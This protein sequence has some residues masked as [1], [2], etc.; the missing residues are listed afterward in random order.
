M[1]T[2]SRS[3]LTV[4][5]LITS[6]N[7]ERFLAEALESAC[8][9]TY[10]AVRVVAVDDGSTDGSREILA[11]YEDRVDVLLKERGGQASAI[12]AGFER[13]DGDVLL[14]LDA[15]DRLQP[16]AAARVVAAFAAD[17]ELSKVQF[18]MD[19]IDAGGERTG[20]RRPLSSFEVPRG[21]MRAAEL[22]FPLDI[23]W[24]PGGG[25]AFRSEPLR[26]IFPI[27][28]G[29]FP[30]WG[31]DWYLVHLSALLGLA[32][33]LEEPLAEYRL[34]GENG[35]EQADAT[36][37]LARVQDS[38]RYGEATTRSLEALADSLGLPRPS[39][40]LS[41]SELANRLISLRLGPDTHPVAGDRR[42]RILVSSV[43]ALRRRFDV[44]TPTKAL[45][46]AW[47][48]L[49]AVLP[50]RLAAELAALLLFPQRRSILDPALRRFRK[51]VAMGEFGGH[52]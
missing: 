39:P 5:L 21:D 13:C 42:G 43:R 15:D 22:A 34:H 4:D 32:G 19:V 37:D 23:P 24:L 33:A 47:F 45:L 14:L 7:Y 38:V 2:P 41:T 10:P 31:A 26:A 44:S 6:H 8:G 36:L 30:R 35:Y 51:P 29:D 46:L 52:G 17:P 28:E 25:T 18:P 11:R 1:K 40:I 27:P 12:N 3:D 50:K 48:M 9:Q 20:E 49:E 16:E